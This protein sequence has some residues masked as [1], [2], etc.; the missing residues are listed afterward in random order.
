MGHA[1]PS[2]RRRFLKA[3]VAT[4]AGVVLPAWTYGK[5]RR[6]SSRPTPSGRRR[7]RACSSAIPA[8]ARSSCGAAAIGRRACWSTGRTTSRSSD[9]RRIVGPHA[10]ET[11]D[12]TARQALDGL[13]AGSDVFVRVSFQSLDNAR[14]ISEPVIGRFIVPPDAVAR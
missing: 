8:T 14:A 10:L 7:C 3:G 11:T 12:F 4:A 13:E 1:I 5:A 2:S 6:R 9:A